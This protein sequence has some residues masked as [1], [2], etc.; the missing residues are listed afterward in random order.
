M[1]RLS[2]IVVT[3]NSVGAVERCL[4]ALARDPPSAGH[5]VVLVD[6]AST[7]GTALKARRD[8]PDIR[9]V[10]AGA[11]LG[12]A[13]AC[14]V[15]IRRSSGE[16]VLLLNPDARVM[17]GALDA[18][19]RVLDARPDAAV[20]GPRLLDE[21]G[22]PE[23]SFGS[24][25]GPW[26]EL[27]QKALVVG[28]QRG[29]PFARARVGRLTARPR[30]VDW[31]SGACLLVRRADADAVGLLDERYFLYAED[32]D[33]CAAIRAR[34]R[35]VLF[36]PEAEVIHLRGRSAASRPAA[37]EEA[38]R[39]S[40]MAFYAKHHPRWAWWLRAYLKFR[41]RLPD[42]PIDPPGSIR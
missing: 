13:R 7:D 26:A 4:E 27:R 23:L 9:V 24:M 10:D 31:V 22:R 2:I 17:P 29:V 19:T 14:N 42:M 20:V 37:A 15:G 18:M 12:F 35:R 3:Y 11:N 32:V 38:Y 41:G 30:E 16:L 5:D 21:H 39:R 36:T 25:I 33:F 34:G 6:N 1:S 40:Q 8:W 28:S